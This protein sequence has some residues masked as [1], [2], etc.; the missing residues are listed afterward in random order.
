MPED[1]QKRNRRQQKWTDENRDR[2]NLLFT[3]G[4]KNRVQAAADRAGVSKSVWI[5]AAINEKLERDGE[6]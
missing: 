4:I 5:E 1:K 6:N 3:R 2:I